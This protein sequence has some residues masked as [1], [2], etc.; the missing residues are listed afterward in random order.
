MCI[1][2]TR[3]TPA[4]SQ[5][6][7]GFPFRAVL[8]SLVIAATVSPCACCRCMKIDAVDRDVV[9]PSISE[10]IAVD[11]DGG[12]RILMRRFIAFRFPTSAAALD[13]FKSIPCKTRSS[14]FYRSS[15]TRV[16]NGISV[17]NQKHRFVCGRASSAARTSGTVVPVRLP[18]N[19]REARTF[20]RFDVPPTMLCKC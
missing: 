14:Q 7:L 20:R 3:K 4:T 18:P 10:K 6:Y 13:S 15:T 17:G 2:C 8:W 16:V 12:T 19:S 9:I 5:R 11:G 1:E